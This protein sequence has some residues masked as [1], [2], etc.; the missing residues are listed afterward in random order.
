MNVVT[1]KFGEAQGRGWP[2]IKSLIL[3]DNGFPV[4][5]QK[6]RQEGLFSLACFGLEANLCKGKLSVGRRRARP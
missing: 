5:D 4:Y 1:V 2:G 6:D 3:W